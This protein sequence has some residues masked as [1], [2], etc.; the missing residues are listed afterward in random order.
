M[1]RR[2]IFLAIGA[3]GLAAALAIVG[4][5]G[6]DAR[7]STEDRDASRYETRTA[8]VGEVTVEATL[9]RLDTD[10]AEVEVVLDTHAVELDLDIASNAV[11]KV[12]NTKWRTESWRGDG[13]GG[14]H[15]EGQLRFDA[16][17]QVSGDA[18]LTL[19]GL[20]KPVSFSWAVLP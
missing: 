6:T 7:T 16:V 18:M 17:G 1:R 2:L 8:A 14:H 9:R 3:V 11:L 10:G 15:R 20:T 5:S 19:E 12:G 4:R 13:P